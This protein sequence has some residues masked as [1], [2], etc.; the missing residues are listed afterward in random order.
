[1]GKITIIEP[2]EIQLSELGAGE[3]FLIDNVLHVICSTDGNIDEDTCVVR[4]FLTGSCF[5]TDS[6]SVIIPVSIEQMDITITL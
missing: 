4:S 2:K 6:N 1:M 3:F 5:V